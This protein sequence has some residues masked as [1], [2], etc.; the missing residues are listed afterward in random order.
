MDAGKEGFKTAGYRK[1]RFGTGGIQEKRDS[2]KEGFRTGGI[3][4]KRDTGKEGLKTAGTQERRDSGLYGF[5]TGLL[6]VGG[7]TWAPSPLA[8]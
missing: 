6:G 7:G 5:R 8:T 2:G 4:E 1:A 3:Q